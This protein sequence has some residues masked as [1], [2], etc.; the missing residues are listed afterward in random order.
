M[1]SKSKIIVIAAV[2]AVIALCVGALA[3]R[4]SEMA[5]PDGADGN[6]VNE[7]QSLQWQLDAEQTFQAQLQQAKAHDLAWQSLSESERQRI[8]QARK[9]NIEAESAALMNTTVTTTAESGLCEFAGIRYPDREPAVPFP[10]APRIFIM[11]NYWGGMFGGQ[12]QGVWAGSEPRNP[13]QGE[14][15]LFNNP[16]DPSAYNLYSSPT[17]TGP[18][19]IVGEK[20]SL[21]TVISVAG[22]YDKNTE[23]VATTSSVAPTLEVVVAPGGATYTFDMR[24]LRFQ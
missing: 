19:W 3:L 20:N 22:S 10:T 15:L 17:A 2:A 9:A 6:A 11:V 23:Y 24:T 8:L 13:L 12:C 16:E 4:A 1:G 7:D 18:L 21:L 14:L 5:Q